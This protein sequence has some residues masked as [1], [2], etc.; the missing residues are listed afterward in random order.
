MRLCTSEHEREYGFTEV[1][2]LAVGGLYRKV[3]DPVLRTHVL[4]VWRISLGDSLGE[5]ARMVDYS[6][7]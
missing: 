2:S 4:R 3:T 1:G 7:E 6:Q 5:V